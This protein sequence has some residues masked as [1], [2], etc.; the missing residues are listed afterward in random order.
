M[1]YT[2]S[3]DLVSRNI[4]GIRVKVSIK[5]FAVSMEVKNKGME[6]EVR[7]PSGNFLGDLV[8]TSTKLIWCQ[9]RTKPANGKPITWNRFIDYMNSC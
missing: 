4:E 9:G 8:V 7:D 2:C 6:L 3:V 1:T 5:D